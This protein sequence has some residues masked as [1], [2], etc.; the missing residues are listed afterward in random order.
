MRVPVDPFHRKE[1][2]HDM[3]PIVKIKNHFLKSLPG[4]QVRSEPSQMHRRSSTFLFIS[5]SSSFS[6]GERWERDSLMFNQMD[7]L[8]LSGRKGYGM[9]AL[10]GGDNTDAVR[11]HEFPHQASP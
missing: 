2:S 11:G 8:W 4:E 6:Q 1:S 5:E 10:K 7:S 3:V 9:E